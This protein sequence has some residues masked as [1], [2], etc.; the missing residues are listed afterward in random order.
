MFNEEDENVDEEDLD[1]FEALGVDSSPPAER[2]ADL[3]DA[4]TDDAEEETLTFDAPENLADED[5]VDPFEL[6]GE[7]SPS[8]D[9]GEGTIASD[10]LEALL[11]D[12][13]DSDEDTPTSND[14]DKV[15]A[16]RLL[17]ET[18]WVDNILDPAEVALL[19]RKREALEIDFIT[20]LKMV[21]DII[22]T[23]VKNG[24]IF[25]LAQPIGRI[26]ECDILTG[27]SCNST[28]IWGRTKP[29]G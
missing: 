19:L 27:A 26:A 21:Q 22:T 9:S 5:D 4:F 6:I 29:V 28:A 23:D 14:G 20:H 2:G 10:A 24:R 15:D 16:Y 11:E 7:S 25:S 8:V 1:I 13:E 12:D 18:V 17:L 3:L